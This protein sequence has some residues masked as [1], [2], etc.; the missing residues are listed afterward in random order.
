MSLFICQ[1]SDGHVVIKKQQVHLLQ[2][3]SALTVIE[4]MSRLYDA[5]PENFEVVLLRFLSQILSPASSLPERVSHHFLPSSISNILYQLLLDSQVPLPLFLAVTTY[6]HRSLTKLSLYVLPTSKVLNH[7]CA[8]NINT[9]DFSNNLKIDDFLIGLLN[10]SNLI[11]SL[12]FLNLSGCVNFSNIQTLSSFSNLQSLDLSQN[13]NLV[14]QH[15]HCVLCRFLSMLT[16]FTSLVVLNL[17]MTNIIL[18]S[19]TSDQCLVSQLS[20]VSESCQLQHL[21]LYTRLN[22]PFRH[23]QVFLDFYSLLPKFKQL[24]YLDISGW[25]FLNKLPKENIISLSSGKTFFGI[26]MTGLVDEWGV[27]F[28]VL[29]QEI[30]GFANEEQV[31]STL[32]HYYSEIPYMDGFLFKFATLLLEN[33]FPL[34]TDSI[35]FLAEYLHITVVYCLEQT[36]LGSNQL[37]N[38]LSCLASILGHEATDLPTDLAQ[39]LVECYA[40]ILHKVSDDLLKSA[41]YTRTIINCFINVERL[42]HLDLFHHKL[43]ATHQ[44]FFRLATEIVDRGTKIL[45]NGKVADMLLELLECTFVFIK[46]VFHK[47]DIA[48]RTLFGSRFKGIDTLM[49]YVAFKLELDQLDDGVSEACGALMNATYLCYPNCLIVSSPHNS[50]TLCRI[51]ERNGELECIMGILENVLEFCLQFDSAF[52]VLN[53]LPALEYIL[54]TPHKRSASTQACSIATLMYVATGKEKWGWNDGMSGIESLLDTAEATIQTLDYKVK[55][56]VSYSTLDHLFQCLSCTDQRVHHCTLW[57]IANLMF[58]NLELYFGM[59]NQEFLNKTRSL[60]AFH[61]KSF[62][63]RILAEVILDLYKIGSCTTHN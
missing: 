28:P 44:I 58:T 54:T 36:P 5:T 19:S 53:F 59:V 6:L 35:N 3:Y 12:K 15:S 1:S 40:N 60:V 13:N 63:V 10:S 62:P 11:S 2:H 31:M 38:S 56:N 9:L 37:V 18:E 27:T 21:N 47:E 26:Y 61:D 23:S 20:A 29:S 30:S 8:S 55:R 17:Q 52:I 50:H 7:V 24:D 45:K 43:S 33:R 41:N 51:V 22:L 16:N 4:Y 34:T 14:Y 32:S 48:S 46:I 25:P 42:T 57:I 49:Q 39:K